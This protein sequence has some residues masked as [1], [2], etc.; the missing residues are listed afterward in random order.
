MTNDDKDLKPEYE[1]RLDDLFYLAFD[2]N[3]P[4]SHDYALLKMELK[5]LRIGATPQQPSTE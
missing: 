1:Q 3:H 5:R 4:A 2:S